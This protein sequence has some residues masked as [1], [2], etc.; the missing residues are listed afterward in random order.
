L[1][2]TTTAA[3]HK[4]PKCD[5]S[6]FPPQNL[7]SPIADALRIWLGAVDFARN[8]IAAVSHRMHACFFSLTLISLQ[9]N[10]EKEF[11]PKSQSTLT[12]ASNG[13]ATSSSNF[14][15]MAMQQQQQH[16]RTNVPEKV[17]RP[18]SP[19]S[20][21]NIE[22]RPLLREGPVG[23]SSDRDDNKYKRKTPQEIFSRWSR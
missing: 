13:A 9:F 11:V 23:R 17:F 7:V 12:A 20:I 1:P 3:G 21:L 2:S 15:A 8:E 22:S 10:E 4:C 14:N 6:I 16:H 18:E 19:H 5:T